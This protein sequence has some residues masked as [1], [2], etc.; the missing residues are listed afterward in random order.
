MN[1]ITLISVF[2]ICVPTLGPVVPVGYIRLLMYVTSL[3]S[4]F[5][6]QLAVSD[7]VEA[8]SDSDILVFVI[9]H[10]FIG[11][12]CD[13]MKGKIKNDAVGISLI[14]VCAALLE[15][16]DLFAFFLLLVV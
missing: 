13:S 2:G 4:F 8:S 7:L 3:T 12:A 6:P 15:S 16:S 14:K 10:Q 5:S 9:P 1:L 11:K